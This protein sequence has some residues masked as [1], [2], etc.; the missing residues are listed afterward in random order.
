MQSR[1]W[2]RVVCGAAAGALVIGVV[3]ASAPAGNRSPDATVRVFPGPTAEVT[4]GK[5]VAY[6][7]TVFN[8]QSSNYTHLFFHDPIPFTLT[9]DTSGTTTTKH[10]STFKYSSCPGRV[11]SG[12]FVSNDLRQLNAGSTATC[13]IVW[14][15]PT[16]GSSNDPLTTDDECALS[17]DEN[18]LG[19]TG[20]C[21]T[22]QPYWTIKEGTGKPGSKGP[23]TFFANNIGV[24][25]LSQSDP[26]EARG[27]EIDG[28]NP[29]TLAG[30]L[31]T[32]GITTG[33][34]FRASVCV[35]AS[36]LPGTGDSPGSPGLVET[37]NEHDRGTADAGA[38]GFTQIADICIPSPPGQNCG[39]PFTLDPPG[40]VRLEFDVQNTPTP[41]GQK[42]DLI[43]HDSGA[44]YQDVTGSCTFIQPK[45][46]SKVL[47]AI[48]DAASNGR[49]TGG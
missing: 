3:A 49:W 2:T 5:S 34:P 23:D 39:T 15:T 17:K 8:S 9:L 47:T 25:L 28:C 10:F 44:G 22:N 41:S 4:Y 12:E 6:T 35:G 42:I 45:G 19:T 33:N 43:F 24:H 21:I 16:V 29:S 27:Y 7:T 46:S 40:K 14:Q 30:A 38:P 20:P 31:A 37:I 11:S 1:L 18:G 32:G 13:V 26:S 48:C 36:S